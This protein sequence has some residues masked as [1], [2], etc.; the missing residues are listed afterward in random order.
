LGTKSLFSNSRLSE[1]VVSNENLQDKNPRK[2]VS[3]LITSNNSIVTENRKQGTK[4]WWS[5]QSDKEP[6]IE[7]FTTEY[8]YNRNQ[9]VVFKI[10]IDAKLL[11]TS[12][13]SSFF[14]SS[15]NASL[16]SNSKEPSVPLKAITTIQLW[17]FRL[18]YYNGHG[19]TLIANMSYAAMNSDQPNC[20][21]EISTRMVDCD[22]W[23]ESV[24][25]LVPV[26]D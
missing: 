20:L 1:S 5:E 3:H 26:Y 9:S 4:V 13:S 23:R 21:F 2:R 16:S 10:A 18:G 11:K 17:I 14:S 12:S 7:G 15:W 22:N 8:S 24:H 6:L 19:A 25:W